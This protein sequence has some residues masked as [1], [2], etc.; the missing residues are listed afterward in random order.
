MPD[1]AAQIAV[2]EQ[3]L[4]ELKAS[5]QSEALPITEF[6]VE[7]TCVIPTFNVWFTLGRVLR[8]LE[9]GAQSMPMKL[10]LCDNGSTDPTADILAGKKI[11]SWLKAHAFVDP[12][13]L[14]PVP[15]VV[16]GPN[17]QVVRGQAQK[18]VNMEFMRKKLTMA[19]DTPYILYVDADVEMP[20]G[21]VCDLLN[22]LKSDEKLAL[23]GILYDR[24]VDHIQMGCT[25]GRSEVM[26]ELDWSSEGCSCRWATRKLRSMG[27]KVEYLDPERITARHLRHEEGIGGLLMGESSYKE[28]EVTANDA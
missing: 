27:W 14:P 4:A 6:P 7:V 26:K 18:N 2:M 1:I 20:V 13:V 24:K 22:A 9:M 11:V 16:T 21:G 3:Q 10:I 28:T 17:Q 25:M 15:H 12:Q 8:A 5:T 19:V 23:A